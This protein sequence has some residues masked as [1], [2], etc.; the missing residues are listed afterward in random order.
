[1]LEIEVLKGGLEVITYLSAEWTA[2]C[3]ESPGH[4]P[5]LR[6]EWF[7]ALIANFR[8][9]VE[10][11]TSR[12]DGKLKAVL[13]L[14]RGRGRLHIL[15]VRKIQ[16]VFN[17]NTPQFD[18][19]HSPREDERR[20]VLESLWGE[21]ERSRG[22]DVFEC[23]LVRSDSWLADL[24]QFAGRSG[25]PAGIWPMDV[26]PYIEVPTLT[27]DGTLD[28]Y[29]VGKRK[30]LGKELTRRLNRLREIGSV[31]FIASS[32][33]SLEMIE[34]FLDLEQKGWKGKKGTAAV[35]DDR[36]AGLHKD[37]ASAMSSNGDLMV[38]ELKLGSET[39][40]MSLN[41]RSGDRIFHWKTTYDERYSRY[42]PGNLLFNKLL[43][44]CAATGITEIDFLCPS[45]P[46]KTVWATGEREHVAIY[47]FR[48]AFI[49][50]VSWIWKFSIISRM[51]RIK[52]MYPR[53]AAAIGYW[54]V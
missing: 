22:W 41:I 54:P 3:N 44:D 28:G 5:F 9:E 6:P 24:G 42:S 50:W 46:Y 14:M 43:T 48:P 33:Y 29:F 35:L 19:I 15:P 20:E 49:G 8:S 21:I 38:Y 53:L 25:F 17:P 4:A 26:A 36:A 7:T 27:P 45:L 52:T 51:R 30:H 1:M 10:I 31:E 23:R 12:K 34:R 13:P 18:L 32:E 11:L 39:I 40:A 37:F 16:A 2:L 47:I